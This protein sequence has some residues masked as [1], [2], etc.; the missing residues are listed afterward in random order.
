[1]KMTKLTLGLTRPA[2]GAADPSSLRENR[3]AAR[4]LGKGVVE[5]RQEVYEFQG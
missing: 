3:R 5:N 4:Y 1:M 2:Q